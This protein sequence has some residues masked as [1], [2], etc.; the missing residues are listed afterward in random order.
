MFEQSDDLSQ[1]MALRFEPKHTGLGLP[2]H[3]ILSLNIP[4]W[5][6]HGTTIWA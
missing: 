2:W 5:A 3:Y 6:S 1:N 4:V